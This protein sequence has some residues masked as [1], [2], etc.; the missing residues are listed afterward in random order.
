MLGKELGSEES[1]N[2]IRGKLLKY[3]NKWLKR[4]SGDS[5]RYQLNVI[6]RMFFSKIGKRLT[7]TMKNKKVTYS[8]SLLQL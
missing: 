6:E 1:L 4:F 2:E 8:N 7:P 5:R 3:P